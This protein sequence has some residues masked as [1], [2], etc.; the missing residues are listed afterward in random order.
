MSIFGRIRM[1]EPNYQNVK[2]KYKLLLSDEGFWKITRLPKYYSLLN[3][4]VLISLSNNVI[5]DKAGTHIPLFAP[6][7]LVVWNS[8]HCRRK[9]RRLLRVNSSILMQNM[10]ST[11]FW[12]F[13]I[14]LPTNYCMC[15]ILV[16][17]SLKLPKYLKIVLRQMLIPTY[18]VL[19]NS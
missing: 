16:V 14:N 6:E 12:L 11:N 3:V 13:K 10:E 8:I 19:A 18:G 15:K 5:R 7:C 1:R 17:L 2:M 4:S 9:K